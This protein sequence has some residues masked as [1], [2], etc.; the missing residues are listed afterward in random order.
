MRLSVHWCR[1][2]H[3]HLMILLNSTDPLDPEWH[4][5]L[6]LIRSLS[7]SFSHSPSISLSLSLSFYHSLHFCLSIS[8]SFSLSLSTRVPGLQL[9]YPANEEDE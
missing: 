5:L 1:M 3:Y 2:S 6:I 8:L 7:F 4:L 9:L